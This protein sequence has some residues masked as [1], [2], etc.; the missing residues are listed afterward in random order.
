MLP[1][2]TANP[3]VMI[4]IVETIGRRESDRSKVKLVGPK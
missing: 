1:R 2:F 3:Y 4:G